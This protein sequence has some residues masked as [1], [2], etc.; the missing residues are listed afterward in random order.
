MSDKY[1]VCPT[2]GAIGQIG[3]VCEY[4]G[5]AINEDE[6]ERSVTF[7]LSKEVIPKRTI[8]RP[9]LAE[10]V[11]IFSRVYE[12]VGK[13][14]IASV[15][16][17]SVLYDGRM[18]GIV[19]LNGDILFPPEYDKIVLY[20]DG[21]AYLQKDGDCFLFDLM[22]WKRIDIPQLD[23]NS[24]PEDVRT[25]YRQDYHAVVLLE[26]GGDST[27]FKA[28]VF[29]DE[30]RCIFKIEEKIPYKER[31]SLYQDEG[32]LPFYFSNEGIILHEPEITTSSTYAVIYIQESGYAIRLTSIFDIRTRKKYTAPQKI[33][34]KQYMDNPLE[35]RV[36][37]KDYEGDSCFC[38]DDGKI[39]LG[40]DWFDD[41]RDGSGYKII[42]KFVELDFSRPA[43]EVQTIINEA[44]DKLQA[45]NYA[46]HGITLKKSSTPSTSGSDSSNSE[47][48][49]DSDSSKVGCG[50]Y[51]LF[52]IAVLVGVLIIMWI[53]GAFE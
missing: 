4:C 32:K 52:T 17:S 9:E 20:E 38:L 40:L 18:Y 10:K 28:F 49:S 42:R 21:C 7:T 8:S 46:E 25:F 35:N 47:S 22:K 26:G 50:V 43:E 3:A 45:I 37:V 51:I 44:A 27:S 29:D 34:I 48:G 12:Y 23:E 2:C 30:D 39:T 24:I 16:I 19:N 5:K 31:K 13:C 15:H 14:A 1:T 6:N 11:S 53:T 36:E 41:N 33:R